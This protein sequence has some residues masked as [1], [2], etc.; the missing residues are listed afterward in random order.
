MNS[1][2]NG[3]HARM[4]GLVAGALVCASTAAFA[5]I[6]G[7]SGDGT[8]AVVDRAGV[9]TKAAEAVLPVGGGI[10]L[11]DLD[12][13]S[14]VGSVTSD[15][16]TSV[17]TGAQGAQ[18]AS[19]QTVTSVENVR[20]L[21]GLITAKFVN[22]VAS[23][24]ANGLSASSNALG[25]VLT[26]LVIQGVPVGIGDYVAPPNT[27]MELPG[28]GYVV[29][30]EQSTAGDGIRTSSLSVKMIHVVLLDLFGA[31]TGEIIVGSASSGATF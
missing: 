11:G 18:R 26:D 31:K 2:T 13:I 16:A 6:P 30:N 12:A 28:V 5:Q 21:D 7:V 23:S 25:S 22:A 3:A 24:T 4:T 29:L 15:W 9:V 8:G 20:I 19:A 1:T 14:V 17:T 27:R 10:G